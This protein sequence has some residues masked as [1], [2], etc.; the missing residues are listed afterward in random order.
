MAVCGCFWFWRVVYI[1]GLVDACRL[2]PRN[3]KFGQ[4]VSGCG[5]TEAA[6]FEVAERRNNVQGDAHQAMLQRRLA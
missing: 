6:D 1:A 2:V 4:A 5:Q 3:F